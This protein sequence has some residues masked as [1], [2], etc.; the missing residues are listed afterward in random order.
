MT[1]KRKLTDNIQNMMNYFNCELEKRG[2]ERIT[3]IQGPWGKYGINSPGSFRFLKEITNCM[4]LFRI[5]LNNH[6]ILSSGP[7]GK[8]QGKGIHQI[9]WILQ[10]AMD[11]SPFIS[12]EGSKRSKSRGSGFWFY[13]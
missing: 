7:F 10:R 11:I 2:H 4:S 1:Q 6:P 13:N 8:I 3:N 5:T 12:L 9:V